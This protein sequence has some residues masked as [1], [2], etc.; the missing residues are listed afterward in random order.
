MNKK[1]A[2]PVIIA[3]FVALI[4]TA[5]VKW[6]LPSAS[7]GPVQSQQSQQQKEI[8]MPEIPLAIK[9]EPK[10][11]RAKKNE[12]FVLVVDQNFKKNEKISLKKLKWEKWPHDAVQTYFI[13][14]D[15]QNKPLNNGADYS[16]A[17]K[18]WAKSDIPGGV[19]LIMDML[20]DVD[21]VKKAEEERKKKASNK[22]QREDAEK[23]RIE[24]ELD[25]ARRDGIVKEGKRAITFSIDQ[26]SATALSIL[27]PG[28]FV[29]VLIV[30]QQSGSRAKTHSYKG[31]R[32]LALDGVTK[33]DLLKK[34]MDESKE[35]SERGGFL[36]NIMG[37]STSIPKN[38]TLEV[39]E[40]LV[41]EMLSRAEA[42]GVILSLRNPR[43]N[44]NRQY[45]GGSENPDGSS[46]ADGGPSESV[47]GKQTAQAQP[48]FD[49]IIEGLLR[50]N[51][52]VAL[53]DAHINEI[54]KLKKNEEENQKLISSFLLVNRVG[55]APSYTQKA[56]KTK[57]IEAEEHER[58]LMNGFMLSGLQT[59]PSYAQLEEKAKRKHKDDIA[60][61]MMHLMGNSTISPSFEQ[62]KE[63]ANKQRIDEEKNA[64]A[65]SIMHLMNSTLSPSVAQL[66][67]K[68]RKQK[69][70][71]EKKEIAINMMRM[72][73]NV[74]SPSYVQLKEKSDKEKVEEDK[75]S[76][77]RH[78][79][80]IMNNS[81]S[82]SVVQLEERAKI[83]NRKH[84]ENLLAN[85]VLH[86]INS[87]TSPTS[88][89]L[90]ERD[91]KIKQEA[92]TAYL[93]RNLIAQSSNTMLY[94]G[95]PRLNGFKHGGGRYEVVSG[96][97]VGEEDED[98]VPV[99]T[100]Y[101]KLTASTVEFDE[102]GRPI[103][104]E[105]EAKETV[106]SGGSRSSKLSYTA[107]R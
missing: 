72:I 40:N 34:A 91:E 4:V 59:S 21:P 6:L 3:A 64:I 7:S 65:N 19:P 35:K 71:D 94:E 33:F 16:N 49:P 84:E 73:S 53:G 61:N 82:P 101:R 88:I 83:V 17:L 93:V 105:R 100:I 97:I 95:K 103:D 32:I 31:L 96:K 42:S 37:S 50:V 104:K 80:R 25:E 26:R 56:D 12:S 89:Q 47:S 23:A 92:E 63:R 36:S 106:T 68:A 18:M 77:A 98:E 75:N 28:D 55:A 38:V 60:S 107:S 44:A 81:T 62:L 11:K 5:L 67:E 79:M 87:G 69:I 76:V 102:E 8:S 58:R 74:T 29:D 2:I 57:Q 9:K 20:T 85:S 10:K 14:K 66:E 86:I 78:I 51:Q 22:K 48:K 43:D 99:A 46:K 52:R 30:S 24:K 13:A 90:K 15:H 54:K 27:K 1:D 45:A 39:S 70:E 41:E